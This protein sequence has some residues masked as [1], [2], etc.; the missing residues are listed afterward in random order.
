MS[1]TLRAAE[2]VAV[3]AP[4]EEPQ[5]YSLP[6]VSIAESLDIDPSSERRASKER[7]CVSE[8]SSGGQQ[9]T[10]KVTLASRIFRMHEAIMP[11]SGLIMAAALLL[12]AGLLGWL[13]ANNGE[14]DGPPL[15]TDY[16]ANDGFDLNYQPQWTTE[17]KQEQPVSSEANEPFSPSFVLAEPKKAAPSAE[18]PAGAT[19]Q[20]ATLAPLPPAD[21]SQGYASTGYSSDYLSGVRI[22]TATEMAQRPTPKSR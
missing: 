19:A 1:E 2:A 16:V 4:L 6:N 17:P 9:H 10:P 3:S 7:R 15:A 14:Y 8:S 13:N 22:R 18:Q 5:P 12:A 21:P 20:N 11:H